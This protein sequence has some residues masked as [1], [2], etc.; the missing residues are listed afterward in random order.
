MLNQQ[1]NIY[2]TIKLHHKNLCR[3]TYA[4]K[5]KLSK[6]LTDN[7]N[8]PMLGMEEEKNKEKRKN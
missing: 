3:S 7:V 4:E 2:L 6:Q 8:I 5:W 1:R